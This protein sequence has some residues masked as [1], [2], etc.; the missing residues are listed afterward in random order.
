M[1]NRKVSE[2]MSR[3]V[4]T[5]VASAPLLEAEAIMEENQI[6]RLPVVSEEGELLGVISRSDVR[7]G[8]AAARALNP[9]DPGGEEIEQT[10]V[11]MLMTPEPVIV[12]SHQPV[13]KAAELMLSYRV[14]AL[15]VL[16]DGQL[17]GI[18]TESDIFRMVAEMWRETHRAASHRTEECVEEHQK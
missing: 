12:D 13:G 9:Y 2:I 5:I 6:R 4:I 15:P 17:V 3:P 11:E 18:V 16:D 14:G 10:A 1:L 7:E 8:L